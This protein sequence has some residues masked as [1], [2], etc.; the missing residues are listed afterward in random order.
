[1]II[2]DLNLVYNIHWALSS[3]P[4]SFNASNISTFPYYFLFSLFLFLD[5]DFLR[6]RER[7]RV[8]ELRSVVVVGM[9]KSLNL[10][11]RIAMN[12]SFFE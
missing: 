6:E 8:R 7:E 2:F 3:T 9:K 1:M 10:Q 11:H 5:G 4:P 12:I